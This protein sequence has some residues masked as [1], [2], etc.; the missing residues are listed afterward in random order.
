[1]RES[2]T[3]SRPCAYLK[4]CQGLAYLHVASRYP[5]K[6]SRDHQS[7]TAHL[8]LSWQLHISHPQSSRYF[9]FPIHLAPW[10]MQY[11]TIPPFDLHSS[12]ASSL[13]SAPRFENPQRSCMSPLHMPCLSLAHTALYIA[14]LLRSACP[15][16]SLST[17]CA[18]YH[19][20]PRSLLIR[21][22]PSCAQHRTA[23]RP[24]Y[25]VVYVSLLSTS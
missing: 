12:R 6:T 15:P 13:S 1:M 7:R 20:T 25:R 19:A 5:S 9:S 16:L 2:H 22:F 10:I 17:R 4:R 21:L 8:P 18:L 24:A 11:L 3:H 23:E 14:T